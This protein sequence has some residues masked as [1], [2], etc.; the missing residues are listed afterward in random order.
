MI[1]DEKRRILDA[2]DWNELNRR[3]L[4]FAAAYQSKRRI[5]ESM[6]SPEGTVNEAVERT[7]S[8]RRVWNHHQVTLLEHLMGAVRSIY[9]ASA[10]RQVQ[11]NS[12]SK[13]NPNRDISAFDTAKAIEKQDYIDKFSAALFAADPDLAK[14]FADANWHLEN[15]CNTDTDVESALG[16]SKGQVNRNREK[17][18]KFRSRWLRGTEQT[19]TSVRKETK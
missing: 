5:P 19:G 15:G 1:D 3:L 6:I 16:L 8:G 11:F 4:L 13:S 14:F 10:K 18:K 12:W 17:L 9:S 7:Y 2:Q